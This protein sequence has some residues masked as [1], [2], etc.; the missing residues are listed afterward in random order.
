VNLS[1]GV[2]TYIRTEDV[3]ITQLIYLWWGC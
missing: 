2:L 1:A 3:I